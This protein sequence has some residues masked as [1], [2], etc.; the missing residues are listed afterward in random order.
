MQYCVKLLTISLCFCRDSNAVLC[1]VSDFFS[2][3]L[4]GNTQSQSFTV[5]NSFSHRLR[6]ESIAPDPPD[7]RFYYKPPV[8]IVNVEV[9][10]HKKQKV[11]QTELSS[12][13]VCIT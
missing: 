8:K 3:F 13:A 9:D 4:Q 1:Q 2:L 7:D 6:I 5:S 11:S 10:A 12:S